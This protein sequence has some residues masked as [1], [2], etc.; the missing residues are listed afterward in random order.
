M[1]FAEYDIA[2]GHVRIVVTKWH[3]GVWNQHVAKKAR[4]R[5]DSGLT[6]CQKGTILPVVPRKQK[7]LSL[8]DYLEQTGT[9]QAEL[10]EKLAVDR[11]YVCRLANRDRQPPLGLALRIHEEF[12]VPLKS[13]LMERAS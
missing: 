10:A 2:I 5:H 7:Y 4:K 11:S 13:M 12:G 9:T 3:K 1:K 6:P 8:A